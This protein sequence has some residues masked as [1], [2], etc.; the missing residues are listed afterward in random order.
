MSFF[1]RI[2]LASAAF[3][4]TAYAEDA[5]PI[6]L[7]SVAA[8]QDI[9][10]EMAGSDICVQS[11]VP[12]GV[13]FHTFEP[14]PGHVL[15][16]STAKLWLTIGLP[17]E[18]KILLALQSINIPAVVDL[19][20][21][22]TLIHDTHCHGCNGGADTHIWTSPRMMK[23]QLTTICTALTSVFPTQ[24]EGVEERHLALQ[25]R[26]DTLIAATDEKLA[27]ERGK[28]IVIAHGAYD[29]LCRDYCLE[30][31]AIE[32][33]GKEATARSLH[34]LIQEAKN[35]GVKTVFSLKQYPKNGIERV[36]EALKAKV[37]ELDAYRPDYFA[38][39]TYTVEAFHNA[40][41]EEIQ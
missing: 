23:T 33:G 3:F 15:S 26:L 32:V 6:A 7:V 8:Y 16:L 10:Q 19:R 14:T 20:T 37:V 25:R 39:L 27:G 29:Y 31:R 17:F 35:R 22:L 40:L 2:I 13:S 30:Q 1:R 11:V 41:E 18:K 9:V 12:P 21:G 28:I 36:A 24:K 38:N 34:I 4:F 5:K